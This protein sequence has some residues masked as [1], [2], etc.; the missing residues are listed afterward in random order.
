MKGKTPDNYE[1]DIKPYQWRPGQSGNPSGKRGNTR[2]I[3][4]VV[5]DQMARVISWEDPYTGD[6]M[7]MTVQ[8]AMAMSLCYSVLKDRN[9]YTF[10]VM[11]DVIAAQDALREA[12]RNG[13]PQDEIDEK[14]HRYQLLAGGYRRTVSN[15]P[16][17][18]RQKGKKGKSTT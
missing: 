8:E 16:K 17:R 10:K 4:D 18:G 9:A 6:Q 11:T 12:M 5:R 14:R 7:S 2:A 1:R 15:A 3:G 13:R